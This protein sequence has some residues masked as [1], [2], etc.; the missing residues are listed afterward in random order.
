V[1]I[2][3]ITVTILGITPHEVVV[4]SVGCEAER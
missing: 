3:G 4:R 2:L 1:T